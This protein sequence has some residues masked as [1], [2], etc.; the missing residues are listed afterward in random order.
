MICYIPY[1]LRREIS[2]ILYF[3][4]IMYKLCNNLTILINYSIINQQSIELR[5]QLIFTLYIINIP[6]K[7]YYYK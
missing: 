1:K 7:N 2:F 4:R 3:S 5:R 6:T